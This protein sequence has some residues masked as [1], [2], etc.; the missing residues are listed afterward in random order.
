MDWNLFKDCFHES[1]HSQMQP[2]I[3]SKECDDIYKKLKFDS[4]RGVKITPSSTNVY[5]CFLET[6]LNEVKVVLL[7]MCPYHTLKE[8]QPVADG[9][10]FG[11][12]TG[13]LQPSLKQFYDA[14]EKDVY[15]GLCLEAIR[16]ADVSYLAK[17]GVLM[18][19]AALTTEVNKAG[20]HL[21]IWAP[22][23]KYVIE[24]I[25]CNIGAPFVFIGK[26]AQKFEKY[27]SPFS[28]NFKLTHP[29]FAA[30]TNIEWSSEGTFTK[31]NKILKDNNNFHIEWL[32][33][34]PF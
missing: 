15:D 21:D 5:R 31:I 8:G 18:W 19:N 16:G 17:Q 7:G 12:S 24:E 34:L 33:K 14:V 13:K 29:A 11:C 2:F 23:T 9:L 26:D 32:E 20:S 22:F 30:R 1:W 6:P 3:E 10:L 25:L 4:R 27:T 28:W